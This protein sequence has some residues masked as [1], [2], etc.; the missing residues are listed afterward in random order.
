MQRR[1]NAGG[2]PRLL[3]VIL[4]V[5]CGCGGSS[6]SPTTP[7]TTSAPYSQTDLVVGT[8]ATANTGN[9]VTVA[10]TG[11]LHDSSKADAK[12]V[13]FESGT[14][15]PFV[16]GAGRVIRGWDQGIV[17][18]RVGGQRRLVIPPEL[19]YGSTSPDPK[20]PPNA[21]LVFDVTLNAVQ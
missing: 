15:P 11:W 20:I 17:G 2:L 19:A 4:A 3:T 1:P 18:M 16:L 21:T 10:Y 6:S 8:G 5:A 12:G 9:T 13:Q 14:L 7:G